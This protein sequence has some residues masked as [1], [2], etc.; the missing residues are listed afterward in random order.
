MTEIINQATEKLSPLKSLT[1]EQN[2]L[3]D[4]I[5]GFAKQHIKQDSP[6]I[7]TVYGTYVYAHDPLLRKTLYEM[8]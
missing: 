6:A 3:V 1:D 8:Y 5:V 7:F 4:Q 2:Q